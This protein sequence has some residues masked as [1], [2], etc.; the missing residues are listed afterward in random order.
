MT[1]GQD[2][3]DD[4]V[5]IALDVGGTGIKCAVVDTFGAVRRTERHDTGR[6]RG[7][8]AVL[9][10]ILDA[11]AMLAQ[12]ARDEGLR[13]VAAGI[14]VPGVVDEATGIAEW[15][16]NLGFR[17]V[18]L[19]DLMARRL[20]LP[21]ALGHDVRAGAL[22][23]ARL[24]AGRTTRRMLFL[25]IGTGIAAGYAI[26]GR[27]DPGAHGAAG[28]IGH[29]VVRTGPDAAECGCGACGCLEAY[30]SASSIARAYAARVAPGDDRATA[31]AERVVR[32]VVAGDPDAV[33]VWTEAVG[34]L[35]SGL[36]TGIALYDPELIVL[37]GGLA[38]SGSV[39]LDPLRD[40]LETRRTFHRVP[41]LERAHLGDEA[42]CLGAALLAL[43][44]L[45]LDLLAGDP[46]PRPAT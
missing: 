18:P 37:G 42:G 26:D 35:A 30:A 31:T 6:D 43:D 12:H 16:A 46:A 21:T 15:S 1:S 4:A 5:A 44:L 39:L 23:E 3:P 40:A 36:L 32:G 2:H 22:A 38:E 25:A 19:R 7:T 20:G 9:A 45:A 8:D 27:I 29:V 28:E 17:G 11:A 14:V 13:P 10:T 34:A 24:G 33:A 41:P